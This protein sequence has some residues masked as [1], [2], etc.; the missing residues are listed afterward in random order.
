MRDS[1]VLVA[2]ALEDAG[3]GLV[4]LLDADKSRP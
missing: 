4:A 3:L 1:M 2:P